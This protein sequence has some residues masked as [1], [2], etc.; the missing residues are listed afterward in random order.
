MHST[1]LTEFCIY[2]AQ[3]PGQLAGLLEAAAAAGVYVSGLC[4]SE[5][6]DR[7]LV[8]LIG[9]SEDAL[10]HVCES[11]VESGLGP[12]VESQVIAI[13]IEN[14]PGALR[15]VACCLADARV[16]IQYVFLTTPANGHP[17]RAVMRVDDIER[18]ATAIAGL[19]WPTHVEIDGTKTSESTFGGA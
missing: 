1:R 10:R 18:A 16:N 17:S 8:R 12:V 15:D 6:K 2:L 9:E 5:Y 11:L 3:K 19:E 7:G 4:V 14:R 13:D